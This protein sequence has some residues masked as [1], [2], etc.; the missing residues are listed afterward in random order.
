MAGSGVQLDQLAPTFLRVAR[1]LLVV[2]SIVFL[3]I[4]TA[5]L[6]W[7]LTN[8]P[9]GFMSPPPVDRTLSASNNPG[10]DTSVLQRVTPFRASAAKPVL[11]AQ[12]DEDTPETELNLVLNG[13]RTDGDGEGVAFVTGEDGIQVRYYRGDEV[14]G[15]TNVTG[16]RIYADGVILLRE[17][18]V[19]RL[20]TSDKTGDRAILLAEN[21]G[22]RGLDDSADGASADVLEVET[23]AIGLNGNAPAQK[24]KPDVN[25]PAET[26][27]LVRRAAGRL[28]RAEVLSL[29]QWA[30][31]DVQTADNVEGVTVFPTN[32]AIFTRSGLQSRDVIQNIAGV[33]IA[34]DTDYARLFEDLKDQER[35]EIRLLRNGLPVQLVIRVAGE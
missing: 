24:D 34:E 29:T 8:G 22:V 33:R 25:N 23:S 20:T 3:A 18:R 15:M 7:L 13:V 11:E 9:E 5:R 21:S 4:M 10:A 2:L 19:E 6:F 28:N 1:A 32:A 35:V 16:D 31:I 30:R 27:E 12:P 14:A 26:P 17:G